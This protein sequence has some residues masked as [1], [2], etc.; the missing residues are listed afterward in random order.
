MGA[1]FYVLN[2]E[3]SYVAGKFCGERLASSVLIGSNSLRLKFISD[4]SDYATGFNLTYKA[5]KPNYLPGKTIYFYHTLSR[6]SVEVEA[7]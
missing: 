4:A 1:V 5:L 2:K 3:S 7:P 6:P